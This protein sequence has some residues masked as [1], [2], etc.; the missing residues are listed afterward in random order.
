MA[1]A[2]PGVTVYFQPVQDV[3]IATHTSRAQY[4]YT[5]VSTDA[6]EVAEWSKRLA[7]RAQAIADAERGRRSETQD[8]GLRAQI[9]VDR[10]T[11]GRLGVTMQAVNDALS[12]AF[13]QRQVSTIYAQAN[14][15]RVVL[16]AAPEYRSD[17]S[18]LNRL[19]VPSSTTGTQVLLTSVAKIAYRRRRWRSAIRTSSRP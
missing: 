11:A 5:L 14:Q 9:N 6:A 13:G 19:Y 17:P 1:N 10:V 2:V 15:Y 3:Q 4:Q 8:G 7:D 18:R 12:N 16:E